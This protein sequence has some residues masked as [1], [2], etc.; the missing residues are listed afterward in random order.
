MTGG[1]EHA[2]PDRQAIEAMLALRRAEKEQTLFYRRLAAL[3]EDA[4][5]AALAERL[6]E[7][8]ADEQ[9]HLS[10][11]TARLIEFGV[12]PEDL[13]AMRPA[14]QAL[15]DWETVA[16]G[17]EA[18]EVARYESLLDFQLDRQTEELARETLRVERLHLER[19]GGKWT[20]A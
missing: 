10:R 17:R 13:S 8:H 5:D 20:A 4:G 19:L 16:H 6:N 3:A 2:V 14:P 11:V 12:L 1:T 18:E 7:L 9:H 15:D